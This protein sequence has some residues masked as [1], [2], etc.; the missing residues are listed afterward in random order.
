MASVKLSTHDVAL[1]KDLRH[2]SLWLIL[3]YISVGLLALVVSLILDFDPWL[4]SF[5]V[6]LSGLLVG[7]SAEK[8]VTRQIRRIAARLLAAQQEIV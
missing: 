5:S 3:T 1:I 4:E 6:F 7:I 8:L 2:Q